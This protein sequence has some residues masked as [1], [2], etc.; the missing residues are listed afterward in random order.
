MKQADMPLSRE[1]ELE[2][3]F[4]AGCQHFVRHTAGAD[5]AKLSETTQHHSLQTLRFNTAD[6]G[7]VTSF[8]AFGNPDE[9]QAVRSIAGQWAGSGV[10]M[11][12][13]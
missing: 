13:T 4:L 6:R 10:S 2:L 3:R 7:A 11:C 5:T 12:T 1:F 9:Q 8:R